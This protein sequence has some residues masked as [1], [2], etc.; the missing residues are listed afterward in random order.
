[1]VLNALGFDNEEI[2]FSA[3]CFMDIDDELVV[4]GSDDNVLYIWLLPDEYNG[5]TCT[6]DQLL[7]VLT[8]HKDTITCARYNSEASA[9]I[10]CDLD[11]VIKL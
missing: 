7:R 6:V 1:M 5:Q 8:G 11:G 2:G 3:Y 10:S 4:S 9:L